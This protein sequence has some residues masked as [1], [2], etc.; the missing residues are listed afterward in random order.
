MK[1]VPFLACLLL[2]GCFSNEPD[3]AQACFDV[4]KERLLDP[5]TAV[6]EDGFEKD[7]RYHVIYRAKNSYGAYTPGTFECKLNSDGTISEY[8]TRLEALKEDHPVSSQ[9]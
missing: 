4:H 8:G 5:I 9:H 6:L 1:K 3:L 2:T 7:G